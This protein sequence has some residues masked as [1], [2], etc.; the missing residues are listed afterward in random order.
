MK[1]KK[2]AK[3]QIT[4]VTLLLSFAAVTIFV[5]MKLVD[6]A[7]TGNVSEAEKVL[8]ETKNPN[9]NQAD[10]FGDTPL[11]VAVTNNKLAMIT[12]LIKNHANAEIPNKPGFYP[13]YAAALAGNDDAIKL[14]LDRG[15]AQATINKKNGGKDGV[16]TPLHA[17]I[18]RGHPQ[19]V[20][21]L[22]EHGAS[23]DI[24]T[25]DGKNAYQL[26]EELAANKKL[27]THES[28]QKIIKILQSHK[29]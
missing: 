13:L 1:M 9:V 3:K 10:A 29:Q 12:F 23:P 26:A 19:T 27:T 24:K 7:G 11:Y 28:S 4:F 17:A 15:N 21:L 2:N 16:Y 20:K 14:L 8:K 6:V 25:A 5:N 22:L 18:I